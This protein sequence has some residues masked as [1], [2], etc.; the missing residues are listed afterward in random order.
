M[1][2]KK[3]IIPSTEEIKNYG[4]KN[5]IESLSPNPIDKFIIHSS[6]NGKNKNKFCST[7]KSFLNWK[8][9]V[10]NILNNTDYKNEKR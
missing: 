1:N 9:M 5:I 6:Y 3:I 7:I 10:K 2:N 4:N 8:D